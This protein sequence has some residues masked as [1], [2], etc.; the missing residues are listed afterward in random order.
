M[1]ILDIE[2][3]RN[4]EMVKHLPEPEPAGNLKDPEKI[5]LDVEKKK[6]QQ[7]EKMALSPL[8]GKIA[9]IGMYSPYT[10]GSPYSC[11]DVLMDTEENMIKDLF[12][13]IEGGVIYT[14]NGKKFDLD[15]IIKR[16]IINNICGIDKLKEY[17]DKYKSDHCHIDLKEQWVGFGDNVSLNTISKIILGEEKADF[18]VAAIPELMETPEGQ[19]KIKEYCIQ[20]C[21][22]TYKLAKRFGY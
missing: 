9:C 19:N 11:G 5:R 6:K 21:K 17:T 16:G 14:W 2:T 18:D 8:F 15:F 20:D 1:I 10:L 4:E 3:M 13:I 12:E 7:I 22:L